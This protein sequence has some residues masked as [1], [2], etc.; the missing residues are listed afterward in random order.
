MLKLNVL[1]GAL[2]CLGLVGCGDQSGIQYSGDDLNPRMEIKRHVDECLTGARRCNGDFMYLSGETKPRMYVG[3][4]ATSGAQIVTNET[5]RDLQV[6]Q[7]LGL[8]VK[9]I[10]LENSAEEYATAAFAYFGRAYQRVLSEDAQ[11]PGE[12]APV[13]TSSAP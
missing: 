2:L 12:A 13:P 11:R 7:R 3:D 1:T 5:L 9:V 6:T 10:S 8:I 4:D